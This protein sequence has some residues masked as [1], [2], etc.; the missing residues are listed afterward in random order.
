[1]QRFAAERLR[2]TGERP[3]ESRSSA[4]PPSVARA[5]MEIGFTTSCLQL[6][7]R[8]DEIARQ[9]FETDDE[10]GLARPPAAHQQG[11]L[12]GA[13]VLI[14][15]EVVRSDRVGIGRYRED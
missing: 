11:D 1:M 3:G 10:F 2:C 13:G 7:R 12:V 8:L 9:P 6:R 5:G 4:P 15:L 14:A